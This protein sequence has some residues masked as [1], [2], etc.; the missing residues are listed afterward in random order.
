MNRS[1][2]ATAGTSARTLHVTALYESSDDHRC[3]RAASPTAQGRIVGIMYDARPVPPVKCAG[4]IR[5]M[6]MRALKVGY[7]MLHAV[8]VAVR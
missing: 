3:R 4:R 8:L 2:Q 5:I 6:V 7:C 1:S